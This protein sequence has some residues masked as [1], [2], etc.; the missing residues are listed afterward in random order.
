MGPVNFIEW[1]EGFLMPH[2]SLLAVNGYWGRGII[3]FS[4]VIT[5]KFTQA[6]INKPLPILT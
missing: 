6:P 2:P 4:G 1:G 3:S 5:G